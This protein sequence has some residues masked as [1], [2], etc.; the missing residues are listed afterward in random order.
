MGPTKIF[1]ASSNSR[2]RV[3]SSSKMDIWRVPNYLFISIKVHRRW[4]GFN[5]L[6]SSFFSCIVSPCEQTFIV[7]PLLFI[8]NEFCVSYFG[9]YLLFFLFFFSCDKYFTLDGF[10]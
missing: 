2:D 1:V 3:D 9:K 6:Q 10:S 5:T 8:P 4:Y 7:V